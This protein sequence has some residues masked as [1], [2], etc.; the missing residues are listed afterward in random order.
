MLGNLLDNACKWASSRVDVSSFLDD[1]L[2]FISVDDDGPG[3]GPSMRIEVLQRGVRADQRAGASGL[4]LAIV[5]DLAVMY[6]GSVTLQTSPLG[7][8]R[9]RLQLPVPSRPVHDCES[10]RDT[11]GP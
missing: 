1:A 7:G 3:L 8:A 5:S 6:G 10:A 11:E 2:L 4:G 9:A